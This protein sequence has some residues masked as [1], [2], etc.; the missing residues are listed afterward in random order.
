M[1]SDADGLDLTSVLSDEILC[2]CVIFTV[3]GKLGLLATAY[4]KLDR[5]VGVALIAQNRARLAQPLSKFLQ[6]ITTQYFIYMSTH[7]IC[8]TAKPTSTVD[9][10]RQLHAPPHQPQRRRVWQSDDRLYGTTTRLDKS[11]PCTTSQ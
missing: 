2:L 1:W 11:C 4:R 8:I 10:T 7:R 5:K 6:Y 3:Y 9:A